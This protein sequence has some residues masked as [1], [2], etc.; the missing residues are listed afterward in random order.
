MTNILFTTLATDIT[1]F[2]PL[3]ELNNCIASADG[4]LSTDARMSGK[5]SG[6]TPCINART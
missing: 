3:I 5:M 2:I 6:L 1:Y 4:L